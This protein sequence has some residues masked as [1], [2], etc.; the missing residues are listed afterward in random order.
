MDSVNQSH[1]GLSLR[2]KIGLL[3]AFCIFLVS[4]ALIILNIIEAQRS[5]EQVQQ[6]TSTLLTDA[7]T[8]QLR[9][10]A[11]AEA[12]SINAFLEFSQATATTLANAQESEISSRS[13]MM[14][15]GQEREA[16]LAILGNTLAKNRD[17][18]GVYVAFEPDVFDQSDNQ[19][20][21]DSA[22]GS[23]ANGRFIPYIYRDQNGNG[24]LDVLVGMDDQTRDSNGIR[25]GE[26]YL[27]PKD[28]GKSCLTDPYIYPVNG[29]NTLLVSVTSPIMQY[30]KFAGIAGVDVALDF[31]QHGIVQANSHLYNGSGSM[32]VISPRGIIAASSQNSSL[33]GKNYQQTELSSWQS[34][35]QA[36]GNQLTVSEENGLLSAVAPLELRGRDTGWRILIQ[37][38]QSAVSSQLDTL[39]AIFD[40]VQQE[41]TL[42]SVAISFVIGV[43]AIVLMF[44]MIA[45][46]LQPVRRTVEMLKDIAQGEGDLTRRLQTSSQDELGELAHW[47]NQFLDNLHRMIGQVAQTTQHIN[48]A[49]DNSARIASESMHQLERQREQISMA[50]AAVHEMSTSSGEVANSAGNAADATSRTREVADESQRIVASTVNS[51]AA[52]SAEVARGTEVIQELEGHSNKISDIL[53]TIGGVADQTNLLALNA[54][55]EAARAGDHGRGF[56]VVADEVRGLAQSTQEATAEIQSMIE[57]LQKG[58]STA[59]SV[60]N[61]SREQAEQTVDQVNQSSSSLGEIGEQVIL[62]SDMNT[63][64]AASAEEQSSVSEDINRNV[65][66]MDEAAQQV[67]GQAEENARAAE[68]LKQLSTELGGLVGRFRL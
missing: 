41:T 30:G 44:W 27:C 29:K 28:T 62:I 63:Q 35:V 23:D 16:S 56:A 11:R 1:K 37:L 26:Y 38:P 53:V 52:L 9:N 57:N 39:A 7:V 50:A 18:L 68:Q 3:S 8:Q 4:T 2:S 19:F 36:A 48:S 40:E 51:I 22:T 42:I 66:A 54:A 59:V 21:G 17:L 58:T 13:G 61:T 24:A 14:L 47:F 25:A 55:I 45:A 15:S 60:M 10:I 33:L 67:A 46:L 65:V 31:V 49:A 64:I 32:A 20:K 12:L 6:R 43:L 34:R 5:A